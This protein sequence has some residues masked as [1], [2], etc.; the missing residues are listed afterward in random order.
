MTVEEWRPVVGYEEKYEVSNQGAVRSLDRVIGGPHGH[1][2]W[3]GRKLKPHPAKAGGYDMVSLRDGGRDRYVSVHTIVLEAFVGP[4]PEGKLCRHLNG[5]PTDNRLENLRWGTQKENAQDSILHGTNYQM[6]REKVCPRGHK[7]EGA[8]RINT[9]NPNLYI[10]KTCM[11]MRAWERNHPGE[12]VEKEAERIHND[13]LSGI[14]R[15]RKKS[16]CKRGHA[17]KGDN[18]SYRKDGSRDC[19]QC[20]R[21]RANEYYRK[22]KTSN[23]P[24]KD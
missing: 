10:C 13:V 16:H 12:D 4:R 11:R 1:R 15:T 14:K 23:S 3:K 22:S 19:K 8:N 5:D 9:T 7:I 20:S 17:M 2:K 24:H 21:D 18:V 6:N